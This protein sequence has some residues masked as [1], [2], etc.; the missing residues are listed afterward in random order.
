MAQKSLKSIREYQLLVEAIKVE[1][2]TKARGDI[3]PVATAALAA[4]L[5]AWE[6]EAGGW[7]GR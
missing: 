6:G 3:R 1:D 2:L 4:K 5:R 7:Q